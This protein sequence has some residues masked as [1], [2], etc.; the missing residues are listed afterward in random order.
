MEKG[1]PAAT[2]GPEVEALRTKHGPI[3]RTVFTKKK[4][5]AGAAEIIWREPRHKDMETYQT[6]LRQDPMRANEELFLAVVV[7][8][9]TA[10]KIGIFQGFSALVN[11][12]L[13]EQVLPFLGQDGTLETTEL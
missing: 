6:T 4:P 7:Y 10:K 11:D 13:V 8:P 2:E 12:F 3:R 5:A 1:Q 9:S